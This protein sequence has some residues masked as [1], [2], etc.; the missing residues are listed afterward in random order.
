MF[1]IDIYKHID[2]DGTPIDCQSRRV[3][4]MPGSLL[5][6]L[7]RD[8][9]EDAADV[10]DGSSG[11]PWLGEDVLVSLNGLQREG[12]PIP[13][14]GFPPAED[15]G[16]VAVVSHSEHE[17]GE[18]RD[19]E[20][21]HGGHHGHLLPVSGPHGVGQV[22]SAYDGSH[23]QPDPPTHQGEEEGGGKR[24]W[25]DGERFVACSL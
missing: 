17:L 24:V 7:V 16:E 15:G 11:G 6:C 14:P 8:H 18:V 22:P 19:L 9:V 1:L 4:L 10:V 20:E 13:H 3:Y 23:K 21:E 12:R 5:L 25:G 2:S